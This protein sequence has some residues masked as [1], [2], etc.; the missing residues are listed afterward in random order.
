MVVDL[1]G[2]EIC[3]SLNIHFLCRIYAK[4]NYLIIRDAALNN[5]QKQNMRDAGIPSYKCTTATS[6]ENNDNDGKD[7]NDGN[8]VHNKDNDNNI[9]TN[10]DN[11]YY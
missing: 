3:H 7:S 11:D 2:G 4:L 10:D 8:I 6:T 5:K 9:D 1:I